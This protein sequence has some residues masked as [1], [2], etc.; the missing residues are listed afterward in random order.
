MPRVLVTINVHPLT[1]ARLRAL[2]GVS[3]EQFGPHEGGWDVPAST[4]PGPD[5][6][7]CK[8]PP[9]NLDAAT[10]LKLVQIGTVGYEHLKPH[11]FADR[12]VR[13]CNARGLFDTAIAEWNV[14]MM[15]ALA[16]DLRGMLRN[17]DHGVWDRPTRCG[18]ELRGK[19]VGL[20]GYGGIGR[21]PARLAKVLGMAVHVFARNGVKP[22]RDVF[23][24]PGVGDPDGKLPDHVFTAGQERD[25]LGGL[26]FLVLGLPLTQA[27]IGV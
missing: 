6:I 10:D 23:V 27:S 25:F 19:V 17:Q 15:V 7:L 20:W 11:N 3:V 24:L 26:D 21:E 22:R 1:I 8:C 4:L 9:R 5:L 2:S 13:V 16:R 12:P 14:G 18:A